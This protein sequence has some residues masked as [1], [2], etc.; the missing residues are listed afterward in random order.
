MQPWGF[1]GRSKLRRGL[2]LDDRME[3]LYRRGPNVEP[4]QLTR[5]QWLAAALAAGIAPARAGA[6]P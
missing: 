2:E 5:R 3:A 4:G 1:A 6:A